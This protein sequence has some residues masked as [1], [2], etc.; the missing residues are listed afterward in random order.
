MATQL[1][2]IFLQITRDDRNTPLPLVLFIIIAIT[3]NKQGL[4]HCRNHCVSIIFLNKVFVKPK[5]PYFL[6][7]F[8]APL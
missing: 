5:K 3:E 7:Q 2:P 1:I 6:Y 4:F 8:I